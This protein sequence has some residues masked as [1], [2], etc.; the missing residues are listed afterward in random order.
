[1]MTKK[2]KAESFL[3]HETI[4][5]SEQTLRIIQLLETKLESSVLLASNDDVTLT[6]S[7]LVN[8]GETSSFPDTSSAF[9]KV[10]PSVLSVNINQ[11]EN[12]IETRTG[13]ATSKTWALRGITNPKVTLCILDTI[14]AMI[15]NI[16]Q[17]ESCKP[18]RKAISVGFVFNPETR[19]MNTTYGL[20]S[21][22]GKNQ[23]CKK[24]LRRVLSSV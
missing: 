18:M 19:L 1:M 15:R 2:L 6:G 13:K 9:D 17:R 12:R 22:T 21:H 24:I 4:T 8:L 23:S 14:K 3:S 20:I 11:E 16:G 10:G 7:T 5:S